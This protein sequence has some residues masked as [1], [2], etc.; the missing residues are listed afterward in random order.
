MHV[1]LIF[2]GEFQ[3]EASPIGGVFQLDQAKVLK[4]AGIKTGIISPSLLS[5]RRLFLNYNYKKK[6]FINGIPI[7]RNYK[8]NILPARIK[9]FNKFF[10]KYY[11]KEGI[12]LFE[13]YVKEFGYPDI[14]HVFDI[15]FGLFVGDLIKK[16][17]NI[18]YIFTEYC[19]EIL[20]NTLPLPERVLNVS[21]RE[22]IN[23]ADIV[24]TPSKKFS[25]IIKKKLKINNKIFVHN[26]VL[27]PNSN[28]FKIKKRKEKIF[29]FISINRLDYNKNV[30]HIVKAF[31]KGFLGKEA[32]LK[33]LGDGP[34]SKKIIKLSKD[35]N[36]NNQIVFFKNLSRKKMLNELESSDCILCSS[37]HETFGVVLVEAA[38]RG[39]SIISTNAE[40]P[41]EIVNKINGL[42]VPHNNLRLYTKS[43]LRIFNNKRSLSE[44]K[45]IRADIIERF[46]KKRYLKK[47][48]LFFNKCLINNK[49]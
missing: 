49:K 19:V 21:V 31:A 24:T 45:N 23:N 9:F 28:K 29:N 27:P 43:M 34:M 38:A 7:L 5:P 41:S 17:Y 46:G 35:L 4:S 6:E 25:L 20:N 8:K 47:M 26:P 40:G 22:K 1:L 37:F 11:E 3:T 15:R 2:T 10:I 16:K 33:I 42:I 44:K 36:I 48:K 13:N 39:I 30:Q 14:L 32:R 12:K 18:P